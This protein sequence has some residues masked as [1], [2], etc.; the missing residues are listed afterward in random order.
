MVNLAPRF[1]CNLM[2]GLDLDRIYFVEA[3][4]WWQIFPIS[5]VLSERWSGFTSRCPLERCLGSWFKKSVTKRWP[6]DV[7]RGA[8]T[9][10]LPLLS[11][12]IF[13]S[14]FSCCRWQ[15]TSIAAFLL[16][17][18][19]RQLFKWW[20]RPSPLTRPGPLD[21]ILVPLPHSFSLSNQ[22]HLTRKKNKLTTS[23]L[24]INY[25]FF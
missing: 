3:F 4:H 21:P 22:I 23:I 24:F 1:L 14:F 8:G 17:S 10:P 2:W 16:T 12:P 9:M 6:K 25:F 7:N 5:F 13:F 18:L 19:P 20:R 15:V 11:P